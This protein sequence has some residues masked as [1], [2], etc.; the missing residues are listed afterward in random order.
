[1]KRFWEQLKPGERR[2]VAGIGLALF[3]VLNYIFVVPHFSDWA[4]AQGRMQRAEDYLLKFPFRD[5]K[6]PWALVKKFA[7]RKK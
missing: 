7:D 6:N 2:W 1:M 3:V 5:S 4:K